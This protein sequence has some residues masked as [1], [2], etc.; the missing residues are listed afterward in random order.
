MEYQVLSNM[1][2]MDVFSVL[3]VLSVPCVQV[4]IQSPNTVDQ[5]CVLRLPVGALRMYKYFLIHYI[6]A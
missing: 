1:V 4:C 5:F 6:T 2:L 3:I